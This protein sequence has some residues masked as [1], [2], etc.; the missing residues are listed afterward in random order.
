MRILSPATWKALAD[1]FQ[2]QQGPCHPY[3]ESQ[4]CRQLSAKLEIGVRPRWRWSCR[5]FSIESRRNG[6]LP[7]APASG[8]RPWLFKRTICSYQAQAVDNVA[9]RTEALTEAEPRRSESTPEGIGSQCFQC[10]SHLP[11]PLYWR[12]AET[13]AATRTVRKQAIR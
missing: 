5:T 9:L 11:Y 3:M 8:S 2:P 7:A 13:P 6:S 4:A 12:L 10:Q 1:E